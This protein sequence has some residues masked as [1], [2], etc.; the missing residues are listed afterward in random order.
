MNSDWNEFV[1]VSI[2]FIIF[3]IVLNYL[4]LYAISYSDWEN[5]TC[6]PLN[7]LISS[8]YSSE[9]QSLDMFNKC[10]NGVSMPASV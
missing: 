5:H 6:N 10:V 3:F 9:Q 1:S 4:K 8:I 2:I 7:M